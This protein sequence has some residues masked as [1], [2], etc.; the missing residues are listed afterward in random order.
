MLSFTAGF[1]VVGRARF[2][3]FN[4]VAVDAFRREG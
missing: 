2:G 3:Q 1:C 4:G